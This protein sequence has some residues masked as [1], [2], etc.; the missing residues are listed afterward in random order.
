[1]KRTTLWALLLLAAL[2]AA[3]QAQAAAGLRVGT[4]SAGLETGQ[5]V[6]TRSGLVVGGWLGFGLSDRL[7]LQVEAV[8]G[9]RGAEGLGLG[10]DALDPGATP[11]DLEMQYLEVPLLLRAGFPAGWVMPSFFAGPYAGFV[12]SCEVTPGGGPTTGCD[13]AASPRFDAC[14]GIPSA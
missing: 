3:L 9:S 8:Y 10:T 1:M 5:D 14:R 6:D 13:D 12:L 11:V 2:P 4:R 7:A